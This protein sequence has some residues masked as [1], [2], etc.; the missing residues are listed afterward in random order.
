MQAR[1]NKDR[2]VLVFRPGGQPQLGH[3][4]RGHIPCDKDHDIW[5]IKTDS[6][7]KIVW[8]KIM[9]GDYWD[10]VHCIQQT[11]D[12]GYIFTG[13]YGKSS[14]LRK[15]RKLCLVRFKPE[16]APK[17]SGDSKRSTNKK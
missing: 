12:G 17:K 7:G 14:G 16:E 9:G 8:E 5:L 4:T 15:G 3:P 1:A 11:A 10:D 6:H 2:L 13:S